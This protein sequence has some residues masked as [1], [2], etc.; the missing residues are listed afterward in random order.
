M[1]IKPLIATASTQEELQKKIVEVRARVAFYASTPAYSAAFEFHGLG[2]LAER[3][4]VLSREQRWE[5]M[6]AYISDEVLNLYATVGTFDEIGDR[7]IRRYG[8]VATNAEFSISI[9]SEKDRD[10]LRGLIRKM[11]ST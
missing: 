2:E 7:L 9:G 11:L 3:L 8:H 10:T 4:K 6:P 1:S 5:E